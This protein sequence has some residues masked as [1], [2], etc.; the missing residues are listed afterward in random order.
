MYKTFIRSW[1]K[2]NPAWPNGLE[3]CAGPK[4]YT[5]NTYHD[6]ESARLACREYNRRNAPGR[7][8]VKMEFE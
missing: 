8:S 1:W 5:G 6:E 3:P 2:E 4:K 7:L